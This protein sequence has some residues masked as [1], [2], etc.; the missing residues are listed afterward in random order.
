MREASGVRDESVEERRE[1]LGLVFSK[2][3]V[4]LGWEK[5]KNSNRSISVL[6]MPVLSYLVELA[7]FHISSI[8]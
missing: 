2:N 5:D 6:T 7:S 1:S 8:F 3:D 4:V